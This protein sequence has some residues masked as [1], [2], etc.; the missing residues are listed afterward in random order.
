ML[1]V[2]LC[3]FAQNMLK[4]ILLCDLSKYDFSFVELG[5]SYQHKLGPCHYLPC[6]QS[7]CGHVFVSDL[8]VM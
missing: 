3:P 2:K 1:Q 8:S 5:C 7:L 4:S 6:S